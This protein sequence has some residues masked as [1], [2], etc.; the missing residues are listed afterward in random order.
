[1]AVKQLNPGTMTAA[2]FVK[3]ATILHQLRHRKLVQLMGVCTVDEPVFIITEL[4]AKGDLLNHLRRD[5][6]ALIGL[7]Q[8]LDMCAQVL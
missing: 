1:M 8:M 7:L 2:A 5:R 3:E 4:M 6:G